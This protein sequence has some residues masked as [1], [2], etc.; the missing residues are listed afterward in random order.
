LEYGI[1][2]LVR[3]KGGPVHDERA[4]HPGL[5]HH[6]FTGLQAKDEMLGPS[7]DLCDSV[8]PEGLQEPARRDAAQ[9]IGLVESGTAKCAAGQFRGDFPYEALD[10]R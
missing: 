10:L 5:N 9:D 8:P 2:S 7:R 6:T 3:A 4:C 1:A